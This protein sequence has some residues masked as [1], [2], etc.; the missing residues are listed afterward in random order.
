[1]IYK[2]QIPLLKQPT[3]GS[4]NIERI[5]RGDNVVYGF[6]W[7]PAQAT[8]SRY[9]WRADLGVTL[10]GSSVT[11][12]SD[13]IVG[14]TLTPG[15][16][17]APKFLSADTTMNNKPAINFGTVNTSEILNNTTEISAGSNGTMFWFVISTNPNNN[18][19]NQVI[20]GGK[21]LRGVDGREMVIQTN[22][23]NIAA[24]NT[25][26]TYTFRVGPSGAREIATSTPVSNP[27]KSWVGISN[28]HVTKVSFYRNGNEEVVGIGGLGPDSF[29]FTVGNYIQGDNN[30][31]YGRILECG[32]L[33]RAYWT[34]TDEALFTQYVNDRYRI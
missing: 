32:W 3:L 13:Q 4:N 9:W 15:S 21:G 26:S 7:T 19:G 1:M 5:Y 23:P 24:V 31:Y 27:E 18:G 33:T 6:N 20:G 25:F 14:H 10:S 30:P 17:T 28:T 16:G 2:G 12:W 34:P 11:S 29:A 8:D 22:F